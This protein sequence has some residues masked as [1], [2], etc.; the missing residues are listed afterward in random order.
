MAVGGHS[1]GWIDL[2]SVRLARTIGVIALALILFEGGLAAGFRQI[3]PVLT[4][5]ILLAGPGTVITALVTGLVAEQVVG[6]SLL[7]GLL[8]GSIVATTDS[9]AIFSALRHS[10][11]KRRLARLLEVE[12]GLNDP[13][14]VLLVI[15]FI[16][17]ILQPGYGIG[18]MLALLVEQLA[19]GAAVGLLVGQLAVRAFRSLRLSNAGLYPVVSIAVA[20]PCSNP[21]YWVPRFST[22]VL[23]ATPA[24]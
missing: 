3:R 2:T 24:E 7:Q 18:D 4:T 10:R 9:A 6:S 19:I 14:A 16:D 22:V 21:T 15:G 17:W 23:L 1:F 8:L 20:S 11:L 5:G 12:S 13:V